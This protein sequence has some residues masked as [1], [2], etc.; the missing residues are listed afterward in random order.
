MISVVSEHRHSS[1]EANEASKL[2]ASTIQ[3]VRTVQRMKDGN[4][5]LKTVNKYDDAF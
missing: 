1:S 3:G 5:L 4:K 2:G